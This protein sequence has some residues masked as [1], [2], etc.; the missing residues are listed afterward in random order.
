[1]IPWMLPTG[2]TGPG[3]GPGPWPY[4]HVETVAH[5]TQKLIAHL[6][7]CIIETKT[8]F[9][10]VKELNIICMQQLRL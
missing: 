3:P 1:M 2:N 8:S 4:I 7:S 6:K 10:M 5:P 9:F